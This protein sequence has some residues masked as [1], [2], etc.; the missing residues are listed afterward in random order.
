[1]LVFPVSSPLPPPRAVCVATFA[2]AAVFAVNLAH[3]EDPVATSVSAPVPAAAPV[4][5]SAAPVEPV[6]APVAAG[7]SH[8]DPRRYELAGFP[9]VGGNSDIGV[10]F[11]AA[12]TWTKFYDLAK[13][14][15]WNIDL[16]LSGSVKDAAGRA[17]GDK[18][19]QAEGKADKVS[20][21]LKQA[22]ENVKDALK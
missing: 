16:L 10:Q 11:G 17:S 12:V 8:L 19:L 6:L 3:A 15:L 20:G 14:Y 22:G 5:A 7:A 4:A 18:S 1:M 21:N 2:L 9:I 13:P